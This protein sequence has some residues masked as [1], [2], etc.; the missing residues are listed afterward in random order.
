MHYQQQNS[1]LSK[2]NEVIYYRNCLFDAHM[3]RDYELILLLKGS[4]EITAGGK[5]RVMEAPLCALMLKDQVHAIR[6]LHNTSAI[7]HV[8]SGDI[9]PA[10]NQAVSRKMSSN[11]RRRSP[12][13]RQRWRKSGCVFPKRVPWQKPPCP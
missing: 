12:L 8:F 7:I 9:V 2:H 3:H 4:L 6:S 1:M 13:W 11:C 5:S 10:F